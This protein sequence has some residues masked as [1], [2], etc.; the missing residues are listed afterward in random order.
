MRSRGR[1]RILIAGSI[2]GLVPGTSQALYNGSKGFL[3]SFSLALSNE[4]KDSGVTVTCLM[5]A[6]TET[7]DVAR[8]GYDAMMKGE[9]SV[10]DRE[11]PG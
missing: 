1:G 10:R 5:P 3:D 9:I 6:T 8:T 4:L 7:M 11:I 2:A